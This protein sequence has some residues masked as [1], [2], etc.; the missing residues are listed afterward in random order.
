MMNEEEYLRDLLKRLMTEVRP[1][2]RPGM[3]NYD[4]FPVFKEAVDHLKNEEKEESPV[5]EPDADD[6]REAQEDG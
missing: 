6:G 5:R 4:C 2:T 3:V 1:Y